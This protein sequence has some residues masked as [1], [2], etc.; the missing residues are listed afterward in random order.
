MENT[1]KSKE[2]FKE[3]QIK[4][5]ALSIAIAGLSKT[6]SQYGAIIVFLHLEA[7]KY[8][9][10]FAI[11]NPIYASDSIKSLHAMEE[12]LNQI[13]IEIKETLKTL[14]KNAN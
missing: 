13:Q 4:A 11:S 2:L 6:P 8:L 14:K 10:G 12:S 1:K 9:K 3:L 7:V 5:K